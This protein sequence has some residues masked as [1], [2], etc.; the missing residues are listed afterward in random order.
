MTRTTAGKP[1]ATHKSAPAR[2]P[3]AKPA[4]KAGAGKAAAKSSAAKS[5]AKPAATK[6]VAKAAAT[7]PAATKPVAKAAATKPAA[8]KPAAKAEASKPVSKPATKAPAA[9]AVDVPEAQVSEP[10][11][12][13][14]RAPV[15]GH[16][17]L[18]AA[19]PGAADLLTVRAVHL[20]SSAD[21][22]VVDADVADLARLHAS[23]EAQVVVAV[24]SAGLPLDQAGRSALVIEASRAGRSVVRLISGDP[25][26]D[27]SFLNEAASP[28]AP[29]QAAKRLDSVHQPLPVGTFLG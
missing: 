18:V 11:V 5:S 7:K 8:T 14:R 24:D 20:L 23:T 22:I 26:L 16:V 27:G 29:C 9:P 13:S 19:G 2:K 21:L 15:N 25:V 6:P 12:K 28:A 3:A 1:S 10:I 4:A 17:A